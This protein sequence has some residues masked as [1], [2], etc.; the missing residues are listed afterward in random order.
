MCGSSRALHT[1]PQYRVGNSSINF[2]RLLRVPF[3]TP[4]EFL[5]LIATGGNPRSLSDPAELC[6]RG[7]LSPA[8][9][10]E[11]FVLEGAFY[12]MVTK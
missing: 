9:I 10:V 4:L 2:P 5:P 7:M 11:L 12:A 8:D 1:F 3:L 6:R